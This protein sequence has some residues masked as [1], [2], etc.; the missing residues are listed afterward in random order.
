MIFFYYLLLFS[1]PILSNMHIFN[2]SFDIVK[3]FGHLKKNESILE[4]ILKPQVTKF[5][6]S[7]QEYS[8]H[9]TE[10]KLDEFCFHGFYLKAD[11]DSHVQSVRKPLT[12]F[13]ESFLW[14]DQDLLFV[15]SFLCI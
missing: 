3:H 13:Q 1:P 11:A 4:F 12:D 10:L 7:I 14:S 6:P 9:V 8:H 15:P 5:N 2:C